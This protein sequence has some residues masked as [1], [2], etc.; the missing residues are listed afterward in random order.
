MASFKVLIW[1]LPGET[2]KDHK[3]S[4]PGFKHGIFQ[5]HTRSITTG[6]SLPGLNKHHQTCDHPQIYLVLIVRPLELKTYIYIFLHWCCNK[7]YALKIA[8]GICDAFTH[9]HLMRYVHWW[10]ASKKDPPYAGWLLFLLTVLVSPHRSVGQI[11]RVFSAAC[12]KKVWDHF[13]KAQRKNIEMWKKQCAVRTG[14]A[15]NVRIWF[16]VKRCKLEE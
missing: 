15:Q 9:A 8:K 2:E 3:K 4:Q 16:S 14:W 5:I 12:H 10:R 7:K 6:A 13:T 1:N 11:E